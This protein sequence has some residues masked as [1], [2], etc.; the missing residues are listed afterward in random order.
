MTGLQTVEFALFSYMREQNNPCEV[1]IRIYSSYLLLLGT[2]FMSENC[3]KIGK[4]NIY[5]VSKEK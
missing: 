1:T 3:D 2:I 4:E 5:S